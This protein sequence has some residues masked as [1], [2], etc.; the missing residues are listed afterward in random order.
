V[1]RSFWREFDVLPLWALFSY[2]VLMLALVFTVT[3]VLLLH[4][5]NAMLSD[6]LQTAQEYCPKPQT[7]EPQYEPRSNTVPDLS[8]PRHRST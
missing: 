5:E 3:L 2:A 7:E 6:M 8:R 1:T 4:H